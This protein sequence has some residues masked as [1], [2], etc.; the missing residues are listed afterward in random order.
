MGNDVVFA[1]RMVSLVVGL[2]CALVACG[3]DPLNCVPGVTQTCACAGGGVGGTQTCNA[4]GS[5]FG[6]CSGCVRPEADAG[7]PDGER[8]FCVPGSTRECSCANGRTGTQ[9]CNAAGSGF[10]PACEGCAPRCG[11]DLCE[12][13]EVPGCV[14]DCGE[15]CRS[16]ATDADCGG[17]ATCLLRRCDGSRGCYS[18][19]DATCDLIAGTACPA[20]SAYNTCVDSEQCGPSAV[21]RR[22]GDGTAFCSRRCV[23]VGDCPAAPLAFSVAAACDSAL[24]ACYLR[25]AGP[26]V[27]PT[28][29]S[30]FRFSNGSYGYCS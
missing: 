1:V 3:A 17:T 9:T 20:V 7:G 11:D 14:A 29:M 16:C 13:G 4:A 5:G 24:G 18:T 23:V 2:A 25:C 30:C 27:C 12:A 15:R 8:P 10:L 6:A 28:G 22:F 19:R 21:C 26:G